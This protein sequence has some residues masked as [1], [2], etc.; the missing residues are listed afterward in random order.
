[1]YRVI[2]TAGRPVDPVTA[3]LLYAGIHTD[4][5]GF[6]LPSTTVASLAV[7]AELVDS[8]ARAAE[9][10]ERL[11]RSR[12]ASEFRLL[13]LFYDNTNLAV[14]GRVAYSTADHQE[15]TGCGCSAADIDTQVDIPRSL[16]GIAMAL[17]FTEGVPGKV[18]INLRGE[19][20]LSVL[21]LARELG[22]GGH[23][24]AAGAVL[25]GTIPEAVARVLPLAEKHLQRPRAR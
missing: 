3:S 11:Y 8:G 6:T 25:D 22:G 24:Q 12:R 9:L 10:G 1:V 14:E 7:A 19:G 13:R 4:T 21:A 18:R 5:R 2:R 17:L 23:D 20:G 15:I 16:E